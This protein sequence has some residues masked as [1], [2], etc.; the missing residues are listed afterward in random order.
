M[1]PVIRA[2][3]SIVAALLAAGA[4]SFPAAAQEAADVGEP[5]ERAEA[6][7]PQARF[8]IV[9]NGAFWLGSH[10]SFTETRSIEEYAEQTT[11][12]T[13]YETGSAFGPDLAVQVAFFRGVGVRVGYSLAS[14]DQ[15]GTVEVSRAHPLYFDQPRA[16]SAE[17]S[18]LSYSEGALHL[19]AAFARTAG[20]LDWTLFAGVTLFRV[21]ADLLGEP[22]FTDVY[23][24]DEIVLASTPTVTAEANPVGFNVGGGLDYRFG[25]SGRFGVG[26][27]LLY[28]TGDVELRAT[29]E[30]DT[31]SFKAGGLQAAAG[32][33]VYF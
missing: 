20:H 31:V 32:V 27:Q 9:A 17:L 1:S 26:I 33:R 25:S 14:R 3:A 18:D 11:I 22:T 28:S 4:V 23:P 2:G 24:Y 12:R 16:A 6:S 19:D 5:Q 13:S 30:T 29:P 15:S 21:E 10:P 8:R 7:V